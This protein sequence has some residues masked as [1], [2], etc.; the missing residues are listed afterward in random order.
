M[1]IR[2]ETAP[3]AAAIEEVVRDAFR[4]APHTSGTEQFIVRDLRVAGAL[5]VSLVAVD[6]ARVVGYVAVS[7]VSVSD[8]SPGWHGLGPVAVVPSRQARGTGSALVREAI[9]RLREQGAAGCVVLGEPEYYGRFG[10]RAD[11]ALRLDGVPP[12]YFQA[13]PF[14]GRAARGIVTYHPA[15]GATA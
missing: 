11:P 2:P 5:T 8:G 12:R 4:S 7:P 14:G 1:N 10:F 15:F 3:D 9:H 13:L 6:A